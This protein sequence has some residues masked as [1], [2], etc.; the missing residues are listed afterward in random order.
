MQN[1]KNRSQLFISLLENATDTLEN[2]KNANYPHVDL[3]V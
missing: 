3:E 2:D 1:V